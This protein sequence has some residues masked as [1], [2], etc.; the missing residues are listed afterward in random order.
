MKSVKVDSAQADIR[1]IGGISCA[2]GARRSG[3]GIPRSHRARLRI[4][5]RL[6]RLRQMAAGE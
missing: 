2:Q 5:G 1:T 6:A 4:P 3:F